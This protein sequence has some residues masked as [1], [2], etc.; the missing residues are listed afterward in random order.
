MLDEDDD[1]DDEHVDFEFGGVRVKLLF[2]D[3]ELLEVDSVDWSLL[4]CGETAA[5]DDVGDIDIECWFRKG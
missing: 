5:D 1:E 3:N 4:L 2:G